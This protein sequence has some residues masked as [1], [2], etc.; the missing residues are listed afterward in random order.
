ME[1]ESRCHSR[2]VKFLSTTASI[3]IFAVFLLVYVFFRSV[4]ILLLISKSSRLR[5]NCRDWYSVD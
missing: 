5:L 3:I 4:Y 2:S 1:L